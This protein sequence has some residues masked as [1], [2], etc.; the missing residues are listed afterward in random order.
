[1]SLFEPPSRERAGF[2]H[3]ASRR[4]HDLMV[5]RKGSVTFRYVSMGLAVTLSGLGWTCGAV[6]AETVA[7]Q[8]S[9]AGLKARLLL[10]SEIPPFQT[11]AP[12]GWSAVPGSRNVSCPRIAAA[13]I[14]GGVAVGAYVAQAA[15]GPRILES[16][17]RASTTRRAAAEFGEVNRSLAG[18]GPLVA[19]GLKAGSPNSRGISVRISPAR[20]T[21][22]RGIS[23]AYIETADALRFPPGS[24]ASKGFPPSGIKLSAG[25]AVVRSGRYVLV[26]SYFPGT[27]TFPVNT[28]HRIIS[29]AARK[30]S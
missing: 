17:A 14:G 2:F 10:P 15:T 22:G 24:S 26:L 19:L 11:A 18:C 21:G 3:S 20:V 28:F 30:L 29:A 5:R 23:T 4:G 16:V 6:A 12:S 9:P 8:A 25:S 1:M 13:G 27:F 7:S